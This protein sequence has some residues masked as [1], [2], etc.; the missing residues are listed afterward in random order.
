M[1]PHYLW[2]IEDEQ[3]NCTNKS[4]KLSSEHL[5]Q[6]NKKLV[7]DLQDWKQDNYIRWLLQGGGSFIFPFWCDNK[8]ENKAGE[9]KLKIASARAHLEVNARAHGLALAI[10]HACILH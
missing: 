1:L 2:C 5:L 3:L 8:R 4:K 10:K 9:G 7:A 6:E